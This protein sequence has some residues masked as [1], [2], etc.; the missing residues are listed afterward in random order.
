MDDE[1][2]IKQYFE[3]VKKKLTLEGKK[4]VFKD[5]HELTSYDLINRQEPEEFTRE[6][7]IDK[8]L[9]EL[10][11]AESTGPKIFKTT[12]GTPRDVDYAVKYNSNKLIIE[13][14]P[15]NTDL[16]DKS[17][18]SG[19]N[20]IK[21]IFRLGKVSD[22]Y[23]YG[24]ATNGLQWV[25]IKEEN[26]EEYNIITNF[27][28]IKNYLIGK[29]ILRKIKLEDI[30]K[31]F[32]EE[33]NALLNGIKKISREDC[34]VNS[35][36]NVENLQDREEIAQITIDRLIF[37]RFLQSRKV[38]KK[39]ILGFLYKLHEYEL[40]HKLNQLFFE[41]MNTDE[42]DRLSVDPD[43]TDIPYLN[44]SLFE[45]LEAE[46]KYPDYRIKAQILNKII[47]FLNKFRFLQQETLTVSEDVIDPEILGYIFERAMTAS[48]R[49][50][51]GAFY[52]PK[53]VTRYIVENAINKNIIKKVNDFLEKEKGYK[54]TEL[55]KNIEELF[56]LPSTTLNEIWN[57]IILKITVCDPACGSGAFLLASTNILFELSKKINIQLKLDN[58]DISLKKLTLKSCYGV[59]YNPRAIEITLLRLWLWLA[60]SYDSEHIEPLP[61]IEYRF[62]VGNTLIGYTDIEQF[63]TNK[64]TLDD[65]M[66]T[67][68][69]AKILLDKLKEL[70]INYYRSFGNDA[71]ELKNEIEKVRINIR[72][73]LDKA[74]YNEIKNKIEI[75]E[76]EFQNLK[77]LHWGLEFLEIFDLNKPK[78]ERGFDV[79]I[80]NPPYIR[81]EMP[82][83][84]YQQQRKVI[85][86]MGVYKTL[87]E[88]WD[89]FIPFIERGLN[90]LKTNGAFSYIISNSY[91]T[92]KFADKSKEYI[93]KNFNLLRI[94]F[95]K[96]INLFKGVGVENVI[97]TIENTDTK[98]KTERIL[99]KNSFGNIEKLIP[100]DDINSIFRIS[101]KIDFTDKFED[102]DLLGDICFISY[103][104]RPNSDE[105]YWKGEFQK[106]N[107]ISDHPTKI[108]KKPYVEAK[109][110]ERYKINN[111]RYLEWDTDRIPKK[112]V[113]PTF[114]ELY[115]FP[116]I[117]RGRTTGGIY[118]ESGLICND[119]SCVFL[120]Y[121]S[122]KN[123]IN[124]SIEN[125]IKKWTKKT[126][127]ELEENSLKYDLKY[128]LAILNS[129]FARFYL[130]TIRR[131]RIEYYFY[132][133]DFKKLPIKQIS[134]DKQK[135]F[136]SLVEQII[137]LKKEIDNKNIEKIN[138]KIKAEKE[139]IKIDL[140]IDS[141][142]FKLY[143]LNEEEIKTI[144]DSLT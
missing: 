111:I 128:I 61:N 102:T 94:D 109:N 59:D 91:N 36:I 39:D 127:D 37:I 42:E 74:F 93:M 45:K 87:Y 31:K 20:Q 104:L 41:V 63:Q 75:S 115:I 54:K 3:E 11:K 101:T 96:N 62:R 21:G 64:L 5:G 120:P 8:I 34:L 43:F 51:T 130:N 129:K 143:N 4:R 29:R 50:G 124:R 18:N 16:Y 7:F 141:L 13:A 9:Y 40:N 132:P 139:I 76:K 97:L 28:I 113:R 103:G 80:G 144:E 77:V 98:T 73:K 6:Y 14:K 140:K 119:S 112:L 116:K 70:K 65:F 88:K 110:I 142:V 108:N 138:E 84:N 81:S 118:D 107:L 49:K 78:D 123:I 105:R 10:L 38:I 100:L 92:S 52:T 15:F 25:F 106:E 24:I 55:L 44:G 22:N 56:I 86:S 1:T 71:R 58:T 2:K 126:R 121:F 26:I 69:D 131:H 23:D 133:D 32:Y 47:E 125:G 67:E 60:E 134:K 85:G 99:H 79:I 68:E 122:L 30:S 57:N 53:E 135:I 35:I 89:L 33:Y 17:P 66:E 136:S 90:N 117:I 27:D 12:D 95:F 137:S 46:K 48:D 82:E 72:K 19:V 83:V 114:P